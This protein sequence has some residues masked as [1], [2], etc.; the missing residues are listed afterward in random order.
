MTANTL[1]I[2][3]VIAVRNEEKNIL[4]CLQ[5]VADM[6]QVFVVDSHSTDR[7]CEIAEQSGAT[8]VQF[9]YDGGWPKKRN[10]ALR[11]LP[12]RND[13]VLVL[14]GD[15]RVDQELLAEISTAI[16]R[17]DINGF[18]IRWKFI[19]LG[20][21]M[22]HCWRHGWMLR[23]FRHGK[24]EYE[25]LGLRGEGGWDA[26]VHE[27]VV[28]NEGRTARLSSW[29]T[30]DTNEDLTFWIR[31]QNEF[32]SWNAARRTQQVADGFPPLSWL[33]SADPV[34]TRK[35]LKALFLRLPFKPTIIFVWLYLIKRGFLDGKEGYYFSRLRAIHEFNIQA[36]V[37]ELKKHS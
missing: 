18:Y 16:Q 35:W 31:K 15:E 29:L 30:H 27:N 17:T 12:I 2:S 21:W 20:R 19:F 22:K 8:V 33:F 24:A 5:S 34:K 32:S 9:D 13:W 4:E 3:V 26:E 7:T 6:D 14:D 37:F 10:W 11:N 28:I 23:L 1:P 25:D 36:K